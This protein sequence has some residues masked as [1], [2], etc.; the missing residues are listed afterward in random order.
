MVAGQRAQRKAWAMSWTREV[1]KFASAV[2]HINGYL[3]RKEQGEADG[4]QVRCSVP[5]N[6][7]WGGVGRESD[8]KAANC[9][10]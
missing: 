2:I 4:G 7:N 9:N 1:Q 8:I 3:E 10:V 6:V 5:D